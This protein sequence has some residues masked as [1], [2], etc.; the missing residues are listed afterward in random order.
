[1]ASRERP[2]HFYTILRPRM[3]ESAEWQCQWGAALADKNRILTDTPLPLLEAARDYCTREE[4]QRQSLTACLLPGQSLALPTLF[5]LIDCMN[6]IE[7]IA[8]ILSLNHGG[9]RSHSCR[10]RHRSPR[11]FVT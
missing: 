6:R 4:R 7:S 3:L 11:A 9:R 5:S 10:V 2:T 8:V 1:M